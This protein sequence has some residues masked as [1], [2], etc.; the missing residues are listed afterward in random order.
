MLQQLIQTVIFVADSI[1]MMNLLPSE[2]ALE[3]LPNQVLGI[4]TDSQRSNA[5]LG[6]QL[7]ASGAPRTST[8]GPGFSSHF[9]EIP[10]DITNGTDYNKSIPKLC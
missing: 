4:A 9:K 3:S 8:S 2:L 1:A 10:N 6:E 5:D 7:R